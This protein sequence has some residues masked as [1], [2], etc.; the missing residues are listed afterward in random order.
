LCRGSWR[1]LERTP[2]GL[3]R[4]CS[5]G[6]IY[7]FYRGRRQTGQ[8]SKNGLKEEFEFYFGLETL[9]IFQGVS[10]D[11]DDTSVVDIEEHN[12]LENVI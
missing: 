9:N 8:R 4:I 7:Q 5:G 3:Q 6:R 12:G 1:N 11:L 2:F 10:V